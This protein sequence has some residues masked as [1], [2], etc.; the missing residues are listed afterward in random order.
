MDKLFNSRWFVK[1]ISFF[2]ALM[3]FMMVNLDT[4][5]NRPGT[6]LPPVATGSY[7]LEEVEVIPY[8]DEER[9]AITEMTETVQVN[10]RG[11]Q[12]ALTMLQLTRP[13]YEVYV[14]LEERDAGVHH[15]SVKHRGFPREL[16]V[17]IVPQFVRVELQEKKTVSIPVDVDIVNENG[18]ADGYSLGTPIVTPVN[19][20]IT[21]AE[22]LINEVAIAKAYVD[23]EGERRTVEKSVP[24]KIYDHFGNE[25]HLEVEPS[26]VDVRVPITSPFKAVPIKL[27]RVGELPEGYSINSITVE[28]REV[29]IFGPREVL[30]NLTVIEGVVLDLATITESQTVQLPV[31]RPRGVERVDPAQVNVTIDLT[32]EETITMENIPIQLT[33][34]AEGNIGEM[35]APENNNV[36]VTIKG[37]KSLLEKVTKEEI[38]A[39]VDVTQLAV[40]QHV[41]PIQVVGPQHLSFVSTLEAATI[42]IREETEE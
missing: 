12:A 36:D 15:V 24:V 8:Y 26:V 5:N 42:I 33:G 14:D 20:E 35:I 13:T 27:N 21:A 39:F 6:V 19:V 38:R 11:P 1:I 23:V 2:I 29:T 31:P 3:L 41:V 16:S 9:F 34:L 30:N 4:Y 25:L 37:A 22:E 40:G 28:P 18:L 32:I 17:S 10:L 7:T